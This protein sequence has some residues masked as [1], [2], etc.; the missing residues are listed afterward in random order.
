MKQ[1]MAPQ[2]ITE[3]SISRQLLIF[4]FPILM[5]TF[6]QQMYNTVDTIIVGRYVGTEALAAVGSTGSLVSLING[7]FTGLGSGATVILS[8]YYGANDKSQVHKTIHTGVALAVIL[9]LMIT[10]IGCFLAPNLLTVLKTPPECLAPASLYIRIFFAGAVA[11]MVYNMGAGILRA[12]GD[13]RRPMIFLI[14]C[15]FTNIILD[16]LF[17]VILKMG[18]AGAAIATVLSQIISAVLLLDAL[19]RLPD[20][21]LQWQELHIDFFL[22]RRIL[23]IGVPAGL[24][25][26]TFDLSNILIQSGINSFGAA[27]MAAWTA[28]GKTDSISWMISGAFGVSI[29]TFVGQNFGAQ[30]YRRIRQ[31]VWICLAMSVSAIALVSTLEF[32]FR[33]W[34]LG[35]YT[36][37]PSVIE[38]GAYLMAIILPFNPIFMPMEILGGAMRGTGFSVVPTVITGTCIC[39]FRVIWLLT[40]VFRWHSLKLL[41]M[42]YPISWTLS[43]TVFF[44]VYLHGGWL[45][46]RIAACGMAPEET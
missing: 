41:A 32:L 4:F 11:S 39:L 7:F 26:V 21:G 46:S 38:V 42:S 18:V 30:K 20:F 22:L 35:I 24:Q 33:R 17:V 16:V 29:T 43:A 5:G 15:C 37:D 40:V 45:R 14:I 28:F 12:M 1:S 13:S 9:G 27:T 19:I 2:R 36:S 10:V 6:F 31:S 44:L 3:G 23:G 34:I 25:F 8:Q